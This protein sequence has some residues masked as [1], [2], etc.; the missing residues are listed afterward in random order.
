ML[1][2]LLSLLTFLVSFF[3]FPSVPSLSQLWPPVPQ[4]VVRLSCA[5]HIHFPQPSISF[6][7]FCLLQ[8]VSGLSFRP[9]WA[10]LKYEPPAPALSYFPFDSYPSP[11]LLIVPPPIC[12]LGPFDYT[13]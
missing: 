5:L 13:S 4:N 12:F 2:A 8:S 10:P 7:L 6:S 3:S 1:D 11:E 9:S